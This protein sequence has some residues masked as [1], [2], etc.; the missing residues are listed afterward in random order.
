MQENPLMIVFALCM[1]WPGII[2]VF[3]AWFVG[4]RYDLRMPFVDRDNE[5]IEI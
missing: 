2:P 5:D 3:A 1:C 4:R